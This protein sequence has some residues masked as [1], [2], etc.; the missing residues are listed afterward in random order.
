MEALPAYSASKEKFLGLEASFWF[1][2]NSV[3]NI[4]GHFCFESDAVLTATRAVR[5]STA[6]SFCAVMGRPW[7]ISVVFLNK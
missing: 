4:C 2:L 6:I 1:D 3:E 5:S 7:L